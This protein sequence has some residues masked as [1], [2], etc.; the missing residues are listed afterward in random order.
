MLLLLYIIR[1]GHRPNNSYGVPTGRL[2][3]TQIGTQLRTHTYCTSPIAIHHGRIQMRLQLPQQ[4]HEQQQSAI[5]LSACQAV[6][7][8]CLGATMHDQTNTVSFGRGVGHLRRRRG[9]TQRELA[10]LVG[11]SLSTIKKIEE[12]RRRPSRQM[13]ERLLEMLKVPESNREEFLSLARSVADVEG[14]DTVALPAGV[15]GAV[16]APSSSGHSGHPP[17]NLPAPPNSFVGRGRELATGVK[18][19]RRPAVRLLT[20]VGT[21]GIGKTRTALHLAAALLDDFRNGIFLV[22]LAAL[23]DPGLVPRA[24]AQV[25]DVREAPGQSVLSMLK[26]YLEDKEMLLV[27]DNF[28]HLLPAG[29]MVAELLQ[30]G[31]ALKVLVTSRAPLRLYGEH[32][33]SIPPMATPEM[34]DGQTLTLR[35]GEVS[36][37]EA[38]QLF[39]DRAIAARADF[40]LNEENAATVAAICKRLD[41]LPLAVELAAAHIREM[42]PETILAR[43]QNVPDLGEGPLGLLSEGA[44]DLPARHHTLRA[45]IGWSYDLL[46]E[47]EQALFRRMSVFVGGGIREAVASVCSG[48]EEEEE[49]EEDTLDAGLASLGEKGLLLK[50]QAGGEVRYSMLEMIK[51]YALERLVE[52]GEADATRSKHAAYYMS[53]AERAEPE[54]RGA[55]QAVWL[56]RLEI[57]HNNLRA[58][59]EWCLGAGDIASQLRIAG[60]LPR[61]WMRG[62]QREGR[63]WLER[64]L[65]RAEVSSSAVP[66]ALRAKALRGLANAAFVQADFIA[67]R[68]FSE[69]ALPLFRLTGD[70][71]GIFSVLNFLGIIAA[72]QGEFASARTLLEEALSVQQELGDKSA[73][74]AVLSNL[75]SV[76]IRQGDYPAASTFLKEALAYS[77]QVGDK[78]GIAFVLENLGDVAVQEGDYG[79]GRSYFEQS[80]TIRRELGDKWGIA[81]SLLNLGALALRQDDYLQARELLIH[82]LTLFEAQ[83]E[84]KH[85]LS[86][87]VGIALVLRK[88]GEPGR[89]AQLL[90]GVLGTAADA[91]V[92]PE[93]MRLYERS[94]DDVRAQL[95]APSWQQAWDEG[96]SISLQR[97]VTLALEWA[98]DVRA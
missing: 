56:A 97:A 68:T 40:E 80:L 48:E 23:R 35:A 7:T 73:I 71:Q 53:L 31:P 91:G 22:E 18:L 17:H 78:M 81:S 74:G 10:Q 49:E 51:E 50:L 27:L 94:L 62:Y 1:L 96:R 41:G 2:A 13:A 32:E 61:F 63:E 72:E 70:K 82:S 43:L 15:A 77:E 45:A 59:M 5:S 66:T 39:V 75:S 38:V 92:A 85:I 19:L 14:T 95:D 89:A 36:E 46:E 98:R 86:C 37:Y 58:A 60:A 47:K 16:P 64:G 6:H 12:G 30:A 21:A 44:I 79:L 4:E 34:P 87:V 69:E 26:Q 88:R 83:G 67:A 76:V 54:L 28:E 11:C 65:A 8:I 24:I 93:L 25:L 57:E 9:L 20:L 84:M 52:S 55:D 29:M 42:P 33:M 90:A 3:G